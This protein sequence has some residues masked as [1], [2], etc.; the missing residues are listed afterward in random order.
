MVYV[1][2]KLRNYLLRYHLNMYT[3][4]YALNYLV[5][6][7]VLGGRIYKWLLLFQKYDFEVIVKPGKM[8]AGPDHLSR[9]LLGEDACNLDDNFPD[10]KLF[11]VRMVDDNFTYIMEFLN[12]GATPSDIIIM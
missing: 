8:N 4:H 10:E 5:N 11:A 12:T 2:Q 9:I 7:P 1:L 3:Y 6:K